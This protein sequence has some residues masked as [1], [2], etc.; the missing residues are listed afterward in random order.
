MA[1]GNP[2]GKFQANR[3]DPE[4]IK[5]NSAADILSP[6]LRFSFK[7]LDLDHE[8]F[9]CKGREAIYF[10]RLLDRMKDLSGTPVS[11]LTNARPNAALRFHR[12]DWQDDRVSVKSFGIRGWEEYDQEAWQFSISANEHGRIH[13]FLIENV[14]YVVW[15]DPEHQLYP[16]KA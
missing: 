5:T 4:P 15:L 1:R 9:H 14:F 6:L 11:A 16:G 12:I 8:L 3:R 13:G 7:F 2:R 10:Q